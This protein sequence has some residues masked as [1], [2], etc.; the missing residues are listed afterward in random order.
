M[1]NSYLGIKERKK[2][3]KSLLTYMFGNSKHLW[4]WDYNSLS[5]VLTEVGFSKIRRGKFND[6]DDKMFLLVENKERFENCLS[7]EVVK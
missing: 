6:S 7:I 1:K 2:G 4:M 5:K 3:L